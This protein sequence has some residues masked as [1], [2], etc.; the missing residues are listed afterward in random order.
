MRTKKEH[1]Y[2]V[3][4]IGSVA[5]SLCIVSFRSLHRMEII[6]EAR[7]R[8]GFG[9]EVFNTGELSF[10]STRQMCRMLNGF[11]R[12]MADYGCEEVVVYATAVLREAE[13]QRMILDLIRV[14]TGLEVQVLDMPQEIYFKHFAL[15]YQLTHPGG[16]AEAEPIN[17]AT[18]FVDITS[19]S[20]GFT[21]WSDDKLCYQ[22]NVHIGTLRLLESF[23]RNQRDAIEFPQV[24]HEYLRHMLEPIWPV[25]ASYDIR[26]LVLSGRE[27]RLV[28]QLMGVRSK[29]GMMILRPDSFERVFK[30]TG[31]KTATGLMNYCNIT[32][33]QADM[34]LPTLHLY[35]EVMT[36]IPAEHL[37]MMGTTFLYGATMYHGA[38]KTN[39]PELVVL[40]RQ[41]L[42]LA[43]SIA[44]R[45][46]GNPAH[47]Q[48]A[49][50][51][52]SL[53]MRTLR[54]LHGMDDRD[55]YLLSLATLLHQTGRF[56]NL[57]GNNEHTYHIIMGTDIFGLSD[58][59][60]EIV[61][62]VA[63]YNYKGRPSDRDNVFRQLPEAAKM[64]VLKLVA[65]LRLA[66]AMDQGELQKLQN[67]E[68]E[69]T[70]DAMVVT[71]DSHVDTTLEQWTFQA[72][73]ALFKDIFGIDAIL[74]R[75][76][77]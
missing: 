27:S 33:A 57:R 74:E 20:V 69:L 73:T 49:E 4:H 1:M 37:I 56:V 30:E 17:E 40:R 24:M 29:H 41:H 60:K 63:Y 2:A 9:E 8:A 38:K 36:H 72:E 21:V 77:S 11:R 68:A 45:Y 65:V 55:A 70:L 59:E 16:G 51:Y 75:R 6:Q 48:T 34:L 15:H 52:A 66:L 50:K 42:Q 39:A 23:E 44:E 26:Y 54:P 76:I 28:A 62:V 35:A 67:V 25:L 31:E 14:H 71:Y 61:A 53:L 19:S 10:T 58:L 3:I 18:L 64:T 5:L 46:G 47:F 43:A 32:E 12:I 13:N 7:R 22:Q